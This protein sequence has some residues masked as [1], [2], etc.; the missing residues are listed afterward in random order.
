MD[1]NDK[2]DVTLTRGQWS[3]IIQIL[4]SKAT[5]D[6]GMPLI[7]AIRPQLEGNMGQQVANI[8]KSGA[9]NRILTP[10]D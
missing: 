8:R 9:N 2:I 5:C 3:I 4:W 1:V 6:V 7:E 10:D